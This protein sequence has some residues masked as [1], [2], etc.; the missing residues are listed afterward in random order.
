MSPVALQPHH[1][2]MFD[3]PLFQDRAHGGRELAKA[4]EKFRGLPVVVFGLPRGGVVTAQV[5][6]EQ[7]HA[8][9]DLLIVRKLTHPLNEE[10]AIGAITDAGE[11]VLNQQIA[12]T[13][14]DT[15]V[16]A[17]RQRRLRQ[18][19]ERRER[20]LGKRPRVSCEGKIALIVDDGIATGSTMKAAILAVQGRKPSRVVVAAPV[21]PPEVVE[22]FRGLADEVIV[23]HTPPGFYS[24]GQFYAEFDPVEDED[25]MKL[26]QEAQA[27]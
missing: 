26:M 2:D 3:V 12:G 21:A 17:E 14:S 11:M 8:P 23:P 25:V 1:E 19:V 24:I 10:L 18:A 4:L 13:I 20:Y 7:L 27:V 5:V 15:W 16:E 6:A 22:K 9:L